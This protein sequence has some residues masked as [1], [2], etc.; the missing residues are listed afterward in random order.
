MDGAKFVGPSLV[1]LDIPHFGRDDLFVGVFVGSGDDCE[2]AIVHSG[3]SGLIKRKSAQADCRRNPSAAYKSAVCLRYSN[4]SRILRA[5]RTKVSA[6]SAESP[7][8]VLS[9]NWRHASKIRS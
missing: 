7:V 2:R 4:R 8:A 9:S 1:Q 3:S 6:S 5:R